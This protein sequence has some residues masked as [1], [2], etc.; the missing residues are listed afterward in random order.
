MKIYQV[1]V[2]TLIVCGFV[3]SSCDK[4]EPPYATVKTKYDTTGKPYVLL[5]DYTGIRCINCPTETKRAEDLVTYY[6]DRV[7]LMG[8]HATELADTLAGS[9]YKPYLKTPEGNEW[10]SYYKVDYVPLGLVNRAKYN[11][12]YALAPGVWSAA[13]DAQL[14]KPVVAVVKATA[15]CNSATKQIQASVRV[16][17]KKM[18]S[19]SA[20]VNLY[21]TEDSIKGVQANN[22]S[23]VGPVPTID[24]YY[25]N[26]VFRASMNGVNGEQLTSSVEVG[27]TYTYTSSY[28]VNSTSWNLR[29]LFLIVTVTDNDQATL[30]EVIGVTKAKIIYN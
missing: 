22:N 14:A 23:A 18:I 21:I 28:T 9:P 16:T 7:I 13:I 24:P 1:L 6:I 5:E 3:L 20:N 12:K 30:K 4:L 25:Y 26:G 8:V 19:G 11:S 17:F 27:K 10:A 15:S 29:K 2:L